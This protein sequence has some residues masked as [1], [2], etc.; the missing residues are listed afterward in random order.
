MGLKNDKQLPGSDKLIFSGQKTCFITLIAQ[1]ESALFGKIKKAVIYFGW[2]A[3][4][5]KCQ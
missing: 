3:P 4:G 1:M 2:T 5:I